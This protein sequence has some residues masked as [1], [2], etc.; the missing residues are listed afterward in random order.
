MTKE[1]QDY[2]RHIKIQTDNVGKFLQVIRENN[3]SLDMANSLKELSIKH[4][5]LSKDNRITL[6]V[7]VNIPTSDTFNHPNR[8]STQQISFNLPSSF[9]GYICNYIAKLIPYDND[10]IIKEISSFSY[11]LTEPNNEKDLNSHQ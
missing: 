1:Q 4:N 2:I 11:Q 5:L 3:I 6:S 7:S 9:I 8:L 10:R